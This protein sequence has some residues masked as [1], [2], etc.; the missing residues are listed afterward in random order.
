MSSHNVIS[1]SE[2]SNTRWHEGTY[3]PAQAHEAAQ[4]TFFSK[5]MVS[6]AAIRYIERVL[7]F[8]TKTENT[9]STG[10]SFR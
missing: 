5:W 4:S 6:V 8:Y 1:L 9:T 3:H 7:G 10:H 2:Q